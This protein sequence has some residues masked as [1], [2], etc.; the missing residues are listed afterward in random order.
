MIYDPHDL[1]EKAAES[2]GE[3][4]RLSF[5]FSRADKPAILVDILAAAETK[6]QMCIQKHWK[7]KTRK[8][9]VI[10]LRDVCEKML[11]WVRKFKEIGDVAVS[12][13]PAHAA[14]PW[15]A[16]RVILQAS[17]NDVQTF[18]AMAEGLEQVSRSIT[19]CCIIEQLYLKQTSTANENLQDSLVKLYAAILEYL[20]SAI[21]YY[22]RGTV[23]KVSY[24][25]LNYLANLRF[26]LERLGRSV[27]QTSDNACEENLRKI[28]SEQS[29][30]HYWRQ[31][32]DGERQQRVLISQAGTQAS[33]DT[34]RYDMQGLMVAIEQSTA[35]QK[36]EAILASLQQ[37]IQRMSDT[38]T[39]FKDNLARSERLDIL[40]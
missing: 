8:G 20:A 19:G 26:H 22:S 14:L 12:Y 10:I 18:G 32:I 16:V 40:R 7:F 13:D 1:W 37:P 36:L 6:R 4:D 3:D 27:L 31:I 17:I 29:Q 11:K 39:H 21:K 23:G 5:N 33:V 9:E 35:S 38:L 30:V 28:A 34:L 25:G 2:L 24:Q 15:A